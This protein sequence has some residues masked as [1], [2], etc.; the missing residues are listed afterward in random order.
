MPAVAAAFKPDVLVTQV[1]ADT[2]H[3]DP[4][5]S[6]GLT[7]SAYPAIARLLHDVVHRFCGGR[8]VGTGGGGYQH[9][10]VVPLVWTMHF[11]E[12]CGASDAVPADWLDDL[13]S[14]E[15]SRPWRPEIERSVTQVLDTCLP[16]LAALASTR[17]P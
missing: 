12:M 9:D 7:M 16:R 11:A 6:L 17:P 13:P 15:V 3:G 14:A 4:L 5:A 8:W 1:G 10:T 2:H